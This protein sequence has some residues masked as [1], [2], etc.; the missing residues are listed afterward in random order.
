MSLI[1]TT[2][3]GPVEG[4]AENGI[5]RW[6]GIPFAAPPVGEKRFRRAQ[7]PEPWTEPLP[8]KFTSAVSPLSLRR[9][10]D[11]RVVAVW[12]PV[13]VYNGR[14]EWI[15]PAW[16]GGTWTGARNPLVMSIST[17][18]GENF[19]ALI[20]LEDD[21]TRGFCYAAIHETRDGGLLLAYCAGGLEDRNCLR[22]LWIR[23]ISRDEIK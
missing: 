18:N 11:E 2:K 5:C 7:E 20:T 3:H 23:K 21:E 19:P 4:F 14:S 17:D 22:R 10:R 1:R 16:Q 12:N 13:P 8:S 15:G 9:L 6:F